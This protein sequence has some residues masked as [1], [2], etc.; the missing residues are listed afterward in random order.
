MK[1]I[2]TLFSLI[3]CLSATAQEA[4]VSEYMYIYSNGKDIDSIAV[5]KID[6]VTFVVPIIPEEPT[7]VYFAV[8]H[9]VPLGK[10]RST[11]K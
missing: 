8:A 2:I 6:S 1:K 11:A 10:A 9:F 7:P 4:V 3:L 5:S